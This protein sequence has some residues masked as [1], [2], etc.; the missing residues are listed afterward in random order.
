MTFVPST[1][2]K[3]ACLENCYLFIVISNFPSNNR[4]LKFRKLAFAVTKNAHILQIYGI[5]SCLA[6]SLPPPMI[7]RQLRNYKEN[8]IFINY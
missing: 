5:S 2:F 4:A 3:V 1:T 7:G 8:Y 6:A